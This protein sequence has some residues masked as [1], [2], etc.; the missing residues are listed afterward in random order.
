VTLAPV[1]FVAVTTL[2]DGWTAGP[3]WLGVVAVASVV[4]GGTLASYVPLPG[5]GRRLDIGCTPCAAVAALTVL[6]AAGVLT[7]MEHTVPNAVLAL[8][9]AGF[10]LFQRLTS[11]T[12]CDVPVERRPAAEQIER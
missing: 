11:N 10:G 12:A 9:V 4:A 6:G 2:A 8:G 1:L 5:T 3:G 7:S